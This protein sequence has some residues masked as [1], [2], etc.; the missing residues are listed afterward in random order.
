MRMCYHPHRV[1]CKAKD[2]DANIPLHKHIHPELCVYLCC[3]LEHISAT[4]VNH[5]HTGA[6]AIALQDLID[7]NLAASIV[8]AASERSCL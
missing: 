5:F 1:A 6:L 4:C 8:P 7:G 3:G 2:G